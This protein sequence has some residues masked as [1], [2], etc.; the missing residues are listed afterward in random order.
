MNSLD[1]TLSRLALRRFGVVSHR[2]LVVAGFSTEAIRHR[3]A[4]GRLVRLHRGVYAIG[5]VLHVYAPQAGALVAY[6]TGTLTADRTAGALWTFCSPDPAA[7]HVAVHARS[8][9]QREGTKL[10]RHSHP[11]EQETKDGLPV[12]TPLQT[13]RDLK[14][15]LPARDFEAAVSEAQYLRLIT[16]AQA[17]DL[18]APD[19]ITRSE[20]ERRLRR[21]IARADLP[22]PLFNEP[23]GNWTLDAYWPAQRLAVEIDGYD[24][25]HGYAAFRRDRTKTLAL[26]HARIEVLRFAAADAP[27]LQAAHIARELDRR[28][29]APR[30]AAPTEPT[31]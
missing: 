19:G 14:R 5:P 17:T 24:G 13:L 20:A 15:T 18:G 11:L 3:V 26:Q 31:P 16:P 23:F 12:T 25:H 29:A 21:T 7:I 30:A 8:P 28:T 4:A 9:R 6:G 27:E 1:E 22:A 2:E 10:H